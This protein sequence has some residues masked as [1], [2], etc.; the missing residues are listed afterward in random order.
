MCICAHLRCMSMCSDAKMTQKFLDDEKIVFP[1]VQYLHGKFMC[2]LVSL[3]LVGHVNWS[4]NSKKIFHLPKPIVQELMVFSALFFLSTLLLI[5]FN[6]LIIVSKK[7]RSIRID[8][9]WIES[10]ATTQHSFRSLSFFDSNKR[11]I[12]Y[13]DNNIKRTNT[14]Y[15]ICLKAQTFL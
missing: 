1:N 4:V 3:H 7:K 12:N 15:W 9:I 2:I 5:V 6:F 10:N 14:N 13:R 11:D 8:F